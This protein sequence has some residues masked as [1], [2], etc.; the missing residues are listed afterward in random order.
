[1]AAAGFGAEEPNN[2]DT[3]VEILTVS[4]ASGTNLTLAKGFDFGAA[5]AKTVLVDATTGLGNADFGAGADAAPN[6]DGLLDSLL[7]VVNGKA[8]MGVPK[9]DNCLGGLASST[10][11]E[12]SAI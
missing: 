8:L 9:I 10:V 12:P 7:P 3:G 6:R 2:E 4:F 5:A 11:S 1:L